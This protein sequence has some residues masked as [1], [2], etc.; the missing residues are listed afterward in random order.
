MRA[1]VKFAGV[2]FIKFKIYSYFCTGL[3]R[4]IKRADAYQLSAPFIMGYFI[5]EISSPFYC[6]EGQA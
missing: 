5:S 1:R 3:E 2:F 4:K 6:R